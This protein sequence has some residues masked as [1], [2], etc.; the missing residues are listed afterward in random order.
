M[1]KRLRGWFQA[2]EQP[3]TTPVVPESTTVPTAARTGGQGL[4]RRR[5][6]LD[7]RRRTVAY[8]I[9]LRPLHH[10]LDS[11]NQAMRDD[12]ILLHEL[13]GQQEGAGPLKRPI[14]LEL[15]WHSLGPSLLAQLPAGHPY[16]IVAHG[17]PALPGEQ[18]LAQLAPLLGVVPVGLVVD[19][20]SLNYPGLLR[21]MKLLA[22]PVDTPDIAQFSRI[23]ARC[24]TLAPEADIWCVGL[25][26]HEASEACLSLGAN[27]VSGQL[28]TEELHQPIQL[29]LHFLRL[30]EAL[31]LARRAAPFD[32]IADAIR[33]DPML[34]VRLLR[35]VNSAG[36][37]LS[38]QV[39]Q[40]DQA[41][42]LL[43]HTR[44]YRWLSLLLFAS[45]TPRPLDDT[46]L[47]AALTRGRLMELAGAVRLDAKDGEALFLI[48]L[49][50]LLHFLLG[51]PREQ[52]LQ[53]LHLPEAVHDTLAGQPTVYAPYLLLGEASELGQDPDPALLTQC[54]LNEYSFNRMQFEALSWALITLA[55]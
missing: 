2:D 40:L 7:A 45:A 31:Q 44:I 26:S 37:G 9:S 10:A 42:I 50:S 32:D 52:L 38:R 14:W 55:S 28:F 11:I 1:F 20:T 12:E 54:G 4:L 21:R 29:P 15:D 53:E 25:T 16:T 22:L 17:I 35:Y 36:M 33:V 5:M 13:A 23:L 46:V 41:L 34:S 49:F 24:R 27:Y 48:G 19:K 3:A 51:A 8:A 39:T 43:G 6:V 30:N 47:E 18:L